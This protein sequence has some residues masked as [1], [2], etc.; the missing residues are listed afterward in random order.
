M[1]ELSLGR[2]SLPLVLEKAEY[3][4][5]QLQPLSTRPYWDCFQPLNQHTCAFKINFLVDQRAK[6]TTGYPSF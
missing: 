1:S 2:L 3:G 5:G 6:L 4:K